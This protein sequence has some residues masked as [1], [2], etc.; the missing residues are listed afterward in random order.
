MPKAMEHASHSELIPF[1]GWGK[2]KQAAIYAG[3]EPRMI[4]MWI[5]SGLR[6]ARLNKKTILIRYADIDEYL[7]QFCEDGSGLDELLGDLA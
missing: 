7:M 2:I 4:R 3:V 1:R 5:E 6:C